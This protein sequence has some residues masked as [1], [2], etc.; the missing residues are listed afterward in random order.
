MWGAPRDRSGAGGNRLQG[1]E[2]AASEEGVAGVLPLL[3]GGRKDG[4][5]DGRGLGILDGPED[6]H[7]LALDDRGV[8]GR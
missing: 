2:A 7:D 6:P 8:Q 1:R 5:P 4:G 3:A